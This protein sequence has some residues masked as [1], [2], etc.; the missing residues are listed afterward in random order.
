MTEAGRLIRVGRELAD[1]ENDRAKVLQRIVRPDELLALDRSCA[2]TALGEGRPV[3]VG[4][5]RRIDR[6]ELRGLD[7]TAERLQ[8]P[9]VGVVV[10]LLQVKG[11][12]SSAGRRQPPAGSSIALL[13]GRRRV[14][15]RGA[16]EHALPVGRLHPIGEWP[17]DGVI[18]VAAELA[19][20]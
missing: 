8:R 15:G 1:Q 3:Y 18:G 16:V 5:Q 9:L 19:V 6:G 13:S 7:E 12:C 11:R 14:R 17:Y 2:D 4:R 20:D 10:S